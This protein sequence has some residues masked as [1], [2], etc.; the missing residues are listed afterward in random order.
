M[1]LTYKQSHVII[2]AK[3]KLPLQFNFKN[4]SRLL[5]IFETY[6][7]LSND[8]NQSISFAAGGVLFSGGGVSITNIVKPGSADGEEVDDH[9]GLSRLI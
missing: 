8:D 2:L 6:S 9:R 5:S 1:C 3:S 7:S 4:T